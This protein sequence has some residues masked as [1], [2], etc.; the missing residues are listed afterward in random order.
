MGLHMFIAL[1]DKYWVHEQGLILMDV[2]GS[3]NIY[4]LK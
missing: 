3:K 1:V 4:N 2:K